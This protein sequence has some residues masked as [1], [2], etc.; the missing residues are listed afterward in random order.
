MTGVARGVASYVYDGLGRRINISANDGTSRTQVYSQG[1]QLLYGTRQGGTSTQTT[2]YI[3]LGGKAIGEVSGNTGTTYLHTDALGSVVA[4]VG[5]V[6]ASLTYS[7]PVGWTLSG[8]TCTQGTSSSMAA[9]VTGYTCP[10]GSTLSGSTCSQPTTTTSAA[11]PNYSC[12]A[13]WSLSGSSCSLTSSSAATPVYSCPAGYTL[14]GTICAGTSATAASATL[15]CKGQGSLQP[16]ASSPSGSKCLTQNLIMKLFENPGEQCRDIA[17][18]KGLVLVGTPI[19]GGTMTCVIGPASTYSCP[20]GTTQS[21]SSCLSNVALPA[22]LG[23]YSCS[24]G[25]LSGSNCLS[26]GTSAASVGYSCPGGQ[27]LSGA[28]CI[29]SGTS[30]TAGTP[31]YGCPSGYTLV[32]SSCISQGTATTPA[33]AAFTCAGG[34]LSGVNCSAALRRT[35]YEA[36]GNTAAGAVRSGIGFTGHV[37]DDDTGLVYMQQRY[38]DPIAARFMSVDPVTTDANTGGL[39][40][41]YEYVHSNPYRYTDPDGRVAFLMP[42]VVPVIEAI[43]AV[44]ATQAGAAAV[45]VAGGVALGAA[46]HSESKPS[47]LSP[48]PNGKD[49]IP[50]RGPGRDFTPDERAQNNANGDKNGCHT[51]GATEPGTKNGNWIPDHQPPTGLNDGGPQRLYPHC[52]GCSRQQGGQVNGEKTRGQSANQPGGDAKSSGDNVKSGGGEFQGTFRVEGRIE[53][54]RLERQSK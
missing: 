41:R 9:T 22:S 37:N 17:A 39:F 14:S 21:G 23:G 29:G 48:G 40:N 33:T 38:Y 30:S 6:P 35:R 20:A 24:S 26:T 28:S 42:F 11:T 44:L 16:Y 18:S 50:A 4:T 25:T 43:G 3:Y 46:I 1:G 45:G 10:A 36:Y 52:L 13:G 49:S 7:C 12:P 53:S 8:T 34:T 32:G 2:R 5:Q 19:S 27:T 54:A 47:T 15:S 51:C 31:I